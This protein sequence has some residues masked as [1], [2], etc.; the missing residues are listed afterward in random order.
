MLGPGPGRR[1]M[2]DTFVR[3]PGK[4]FGESDGHERLIRPVGVRPGIEYQSSKRGWW[5]HIWSPG[6][7]LPELGYSGTRYRRMTVRV[8]FDQGQFQGKSCVVSHTIRNKGWSDADYISIT[9]SI[10]SGFPDTFTIQDQLLQA[11]GPTTRTS[12]GRYLDTSVGQFKVCHFFWEMSDPE[13]WSVH[14]DAAFRRSLVVENHVSSSVGVQGIGSVDDYFRARGSKYIQYDDDSEQIVTLPPGHYWSQEVS[15]A[16][17]TT[18]FSTPAFSSYNLGSGYI[19][20]DGSDGFIPD[21]SNIP[22]WMRRFGIAGRMHCIIAMPS[23]PIGSLYWTI[24]GSGSSPVTWPGYVRANGELECYSVANQ[25][26]PTITDGRLRPPGPDW[27]NPPGTMNGLLKPVPGG[28]PFLRF[29]YPGMQ[30]IG[31]DAGSL[32]PVGPSCIPGIAPM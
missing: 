14:L 16:S 31:T 27:F 22:I 9:E 23:I 5:E 8:E 21:L 2:S 6:G 32:H 13:P 12:I 15:R 19:Y 28:V 25:N 17:S 18:P 30:W 4:E 29:T 1:A 20:D 11:F 10:S 3:P 26:M 7:T 24:I